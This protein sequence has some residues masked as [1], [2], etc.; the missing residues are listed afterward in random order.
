VDDADDGDMAAAVVDA[1]T[2]ADDDDVAAVV[3]AGTIHVAHH[4][5]H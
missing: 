4:Q 3:G 1:G 2:D 5:L